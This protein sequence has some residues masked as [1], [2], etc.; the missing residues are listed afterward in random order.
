MD[1]YLE[2]HAAFAKWRK[3]YRARAI[4]LGLIQPMLNERPEPGELDLP[5]DD[6]QG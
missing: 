6:E 5:A 3:R 1:L 2:R 4:K